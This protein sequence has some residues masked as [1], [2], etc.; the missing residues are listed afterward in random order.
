M[1]G[2]LI[3]GNCYLKKKFKENDE[4]NSKNTF[5]GLFPNYFKP[6]VNWF[7]KTSLRKYCNLRWRGQM[8]SKK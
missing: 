5:F 8:F 2:M 6:N 1:L 4:I 7:A 3:D